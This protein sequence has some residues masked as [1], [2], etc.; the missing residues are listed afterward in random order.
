MFIVKPR[1][2][3]VV[4]SSPTLSF[5]SPASLSTSSVCRLLAELGK[6]GSCGLGGDEVCTRMGGGGAA[7]EARRFITGFGVT[8]AGDG[9]KPV[10]VRVSELV[11]EALGE[12][13]SSTW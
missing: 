13:R 7:R 10:A 1:R 6:D 9:A 8:N 5:S 11:T 4:T 2:L 12:N 3:G